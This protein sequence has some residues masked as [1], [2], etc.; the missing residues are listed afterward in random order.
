[1]KHMGSRAVVIVCRDEQA[2]KQRFGIAE[3]ELGIV[4]TRTGRRFFNEPEIERQFLDRLRA[5]L[6]AAGFWSNFN[7]TW[8]SLDCELMPWSAKAQ[9]LLR[10]Q[11]AAV[12]SAGRASLP[13]AVAALEQAA[14]RLRDGDKAHLEA[15]KDEYRSREQNIAKFVAAYRQYC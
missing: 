10:A 1:E 2:A 11:Y 14:A 3:N 8:A 5:A 9:D 12:G 13:R 6:T 7:T 4:Y 15:V